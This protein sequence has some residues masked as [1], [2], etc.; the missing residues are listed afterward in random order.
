MADN[1]PKQTPREFLS[2]FIGLYQSFPY[3]WL[4]KSK[5]LGTVPVVEGLRRNGH[6]LYDSESKNYFLGLILGN[7]TLEASMNTQ[8]SFCNY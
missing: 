3:L 1:V 7:I 6:I 8:L 5:E 2:D 4:I